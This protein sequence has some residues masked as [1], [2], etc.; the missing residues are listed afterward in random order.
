MIEYVRG[1]LDELTP[2]QAVVEC[3]G[4]GYLLNISLNTYTAIQGKSNVRLFVYEVIREDSYVLYGF[5]SKTEREMFTMLIS[6]SGIGGNTART[7]LSAFSL[8]ELCDVIMTGNERMLKTV[9]GLGVKTAQRVIVELKDKVASLGVP[10]SGTAD[11]AM[12][13]VHS[14]VHDEAIE[15]LKMLGFPP[16][17]VTKV[18]RSILKEKP[19]SPV[20][21]VVKMALKML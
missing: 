16:A 20:E 8:N 17:P 19:D 9:K 5:E 3:S 11:A 1:I 2:A 14:E 18:V 10:V 21:E 6:V 15:A 12:A 13:I 4:V 7:I